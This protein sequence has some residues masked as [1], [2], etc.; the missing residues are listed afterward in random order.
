MNVEEFKLLVKGLKAAYPSQNFLP[1]DY[2]MK[3]W[4]SLLKDV[5]YALAEAAAYKHICTSRFPPTIA[6]LRAQCTQVTEEKPKTWLDG[7][8]IVQK[9]IGRGGIFRQEEAMND[10]NE[11]DPI[12]ASIV[13]RMGWKNL[14]NSENQSVDRANF[15]QCYE[16]MQNRERETASLPSGLNSRL[17]KLAEDFVKKTV[18][19]GDTH[20]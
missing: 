14:C 18:R 20:E 16:T 10:L 17:K 19:M 1:D 5:D 11:A 7:W 9:M 6:D 15:R 4:Y 2:S 12:T 13:E 8:S 3:L